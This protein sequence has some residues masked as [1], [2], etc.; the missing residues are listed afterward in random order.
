MSSTSSTADAP[1]DP[2]IAGWSTE[3]AS[4]LSGLREG[5]IS[6]A[7]R[8]MLGIVWGAV[9]FAFAAVWQAS[10]QIGIATWWLGPRSDPNPSV[11]RLLP[12]ALAF[13]VLAAIAYDVRRLLTVSG[14]AAALIVLGCLADLDRSVGLA[15]TEIAI[16]VAVGLTTV[17]ATTGR[18]RAVPVAEQPETPSAAGG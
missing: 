15:V 10:V 2:P 18:I 16:G 17:A 14:A 4:R 8:A 5:S 13:V 1:V 6:F 12:F 7:W 9:L 3:S 11:V